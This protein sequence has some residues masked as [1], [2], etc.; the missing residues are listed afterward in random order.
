MALAVSLSLFLGSSAITETDLFAM[1]FCASGLRLV[2]V[3]GLSLFV[4]FYIRRSFDNK[5]IELLLSRPVSRIS[6]VAAFSCAFSLIGL[7]IA[8]MVIVTVFAAFPNAIS[9]GHALWAFS[10][11]LEFVMLANVALFFAMVLPNAMIGSLAVM[12][13]YLLSR[14]MGQILGIVDSGLIEGNMVYLSYIMQFISIVVPRFD[15]MGQSSWLVYGRE[16]ASFL[17]LTAH[18]VIFISYIN[19]ATFIDLIKRQF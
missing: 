1:V 10:V 14:L 5:D 12:G 15:L 3:M 16:G 17:L 2:G 13:L 6:F 18:A 8:A 7:I 4:I 11:A 9:D 19:I